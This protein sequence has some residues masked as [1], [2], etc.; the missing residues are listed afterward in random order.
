MNP[1]PPRHGIKDYL[2]PFLIIVAIG[3]CAALGVRL[4]SLMNA[5]QEDSSFSM[6]GKAALTTLKGEVE[7]Y[8]PASQAWKI[9]TDENTL[10]SEE[11]VRTA[12][13]GMAKLVFDDGSVLTLGNSSEI[14]IDNLENSLGKKTVALTLVRGAAWV[15]AATTAGKDF[16]IGNDLIKLTDPTGDILFVVG[17]TETGTSVV[18]GEITATVLDP[19]NTDEPELKTY[20]VKAGETIS[21]S[22]R[23]INLLRIGGEIELIKKT[24]TEVTT[25]PLYLAMHGEAAAT[26]TTTETT[27]TDA[28]GKATTVTGDTLPSDV[29]EKNPATETTTPATTV[30]GSK[31]ATPVVIT[32]SGKIKALTSPVAISGSVS[33]D[34]VKVEVAYGSNPAFAL[35]KFVAGSGN[36]KYN[37]SV[38]VGNL[39]EG[40]NSYTVVGYDADGNKTPT[41][42]FTIEYTP[43]TTTTDAT[44]T[45][46]A[47]TP[48]VSSEGVPAVGS[49]TFAAPTVSQ[50]A[51]GATLTTAPVLLSGSVSAGTKE[52]YVN[53][54]ALSKFVAGSTSWY[55]NADPKYGNLK[56]GENEYEIEAISDTGDKSSVTIKITYKPAAVTPAAE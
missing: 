55:Y 4:W 21:I 53:G 26:T 54:Y 49:A 52:V 29:S 50:P 42:K 28:D 34:I 45:T 20:V 46:P 18:A 5:N 47:T 39:K 16:S 33:T 10:N 35:S 15:A 8:L 56:E 40:V 44:T 43:T 41:G 36:W 7:A 25:S 37:A 22:E 27:T 3:V 14:K 6:S 24:S 1:L 13:D 48:A 2:L 23:R 30:V 31:L 32:N 17:E 51:D 19:K 11:G 9:I 12:A 38:T